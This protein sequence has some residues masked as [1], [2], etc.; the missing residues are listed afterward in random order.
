MK[1][2][3]WTPSSCVFNDLKDQTPSPLYLPE[4]NA[5]DSDDSRV[6]AKT[7]NNQAKSKEC[8]RYSTILHWSI[9]RKPLSI[10]SVHYY[11][12]FQKWTRMK[13]MYQ[14]TEFISMNDFHSEPNWKTMYQSI[15]FL[16]KNYFNSELKRKTMYQ[17]IEFIP[18]NYFHSEPNWKTPCISLLSS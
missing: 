11:G 17:S 3:L 4:A 18:M 16:P 10:H 6:F 15:E 12:W 5:M 9:L 14:S 2:K 8:K 7:K 1:E 13:P